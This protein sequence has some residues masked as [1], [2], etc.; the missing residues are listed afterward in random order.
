MPEIEARK[1]A[2]A[3]EKQG[4]RDAF[5]AGAADKWNLKADDAGAHDVLNCPLPFPVYADT[6]HR[7]H[8]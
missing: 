6:V 2:V 8:Q 1:Q 3:A 5:E 4:G 7:L